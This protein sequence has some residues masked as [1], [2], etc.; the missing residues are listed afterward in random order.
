MLIKKKST[1]L[2][3]FFFCFCVLGC[4]KYEEDKISGNVAPPDLTIENTL[5][6]RYVTRSYILVLG[7]EPL[8]TE[9]SNSLNI[10]Q[11]GRLS[12]TSRIIYLQTVFANADYR[13]HVYEDTRFNLLRDNDSNDVQ[14]F[15]YLFNNALMD[16]TQLQAWPIYQYELN[17]LN[18]L[19][20][21]KQLFLNDSIKMKAVHR[22]MVNNFFYDQINMNA[23]NF[24]LA[25]FQQLINRAPTQSE[26]QSGVNMVNG[27]NS[28]ILFQ[29]G[30]SKDDFLNI[31]LNSDDYYEGQIVQ[32]YNKY[33]LRP[34]NSQEMSAG[35][36]LYRNT[37]DYEKV[38]IEILKSDAFVQY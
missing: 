9:L 25:V 38:Q 27:L 8:A 23:Q 15:I 10:L 3:M 13:N 20:V 33:L 18:E 4:S 6:E 11:Q 14:L 7:R 19:S 21:T 17:R 26:L 5:Y 1:P 36:I 31:I 37:G 2:L 12:D 34:P 32:L 24:V 29:A 22:R 16:T 30:A 35:T 28:S